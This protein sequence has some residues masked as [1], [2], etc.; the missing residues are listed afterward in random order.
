VSTTKGRISRPNMR[1]REKNEGRRRLF[2]K[3][4]N[5]RRGKIAKGSRHVL[6]KE[7]VRASGNKCCGQ[8]GTR[9]G[10]ESGLYLT[11]KV[12]GGWKRPY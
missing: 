4:P 7:I 5:M 9:W 6:L 11:E 2:K 3:P 12:S 10:E 8:E 1:H